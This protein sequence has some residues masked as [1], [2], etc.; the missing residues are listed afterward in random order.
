MSPFYCAK[1]KKHFQSQFRVSGMCYFWVRYGPFALNKFLLVQTIIITIIYLL[2]L[3]SVQN[4]LKNSYS[5]S[6]AIFSLERVMNIIFIYLLPPIIVKKFKKILTAGPELWGCTIFWAINGLF[7]TMRIFF[8]K[9]VNNPCS[10]HS[11]L[12]TCQISKSDDDLLKKYWWLKNTE[13]SLAKRHFS[14]ITWGQDFSQA[15]SLHEMLINHKN[16]R[17]TA[18]PDKT[19]DTIFLKC[20]KTVFLG[21][22]RLFLVIFARRQFA[23]KKL[24]LFHPIIYGPLTSCYVS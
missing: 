23:S 12:S 5:S 13:I 17:S 24:P 14:T 10:F 7:A 20:P 4:F 2:A 18:I 9:P 8:R 16:S 21:H 19:H 22:F 15:F 1:F 11:C 3:F 6:R